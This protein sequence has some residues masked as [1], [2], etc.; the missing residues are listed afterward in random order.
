MTAIRGK[1]IILFLIWACVLIAWPKLCLA[2]TLVW[3]PS[4]GNVDGY[5]VYYGTSPGDQSSS[6]DAGNAT[7]Y[8]LNNLPLSE[9]VT[10][11]ICVSAYNTAGESP[12][13][14][15]VV[16]TPGDSTPPAP[17]LGAAPLGPA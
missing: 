14:P 16:F 6:V 8:D 11:Y 15:P 13:C 9:G 5:N 12:P 7:Q 10:Y 17:P 2:E 1:T 4:S 3:S